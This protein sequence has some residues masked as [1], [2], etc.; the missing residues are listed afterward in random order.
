MNTSITF[1]DHTR[2]MQQIPIIFHRNMRCNS[3]ELKY[4]NWHENIE[5]LRVAQGTGAVLCGKTL[6]DIKKD[7]IFIINAN[8]LHAIISSSFIQYDCLIIDREFAFYNG[9][10]TNKLLFE[11]YVHNREILILFDRICDIMDKTSPLLIDINAALLPLLCALY[12]QYA[13]KIPA[14]YSTQKKNDPIK[15]ALLY[16]KANL[17]KNLTLDTIADAAGISK[18]HFLRKFKSVTGFSPMQYVNIQRCELAKILLSEKNYTIKQIAQLIGF[19][20]PSYFSKVFFDITGT[21]PSKY[22]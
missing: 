7:D 16:I 19:E 13:K 22:K 20:N 14:E 10:D 1:E 18:Y 12:H 11:N 3:K 8:M 9:L 15:T 5:I 4:I 2:Q 6:F 21:L 17:A